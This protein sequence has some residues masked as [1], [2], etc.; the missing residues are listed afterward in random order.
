MIG[1]RPRASPGGGD[2]WVAGAALAVGV[3]LDRGRMLAAVI[4]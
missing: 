1:R 2:E 4:P 3:D